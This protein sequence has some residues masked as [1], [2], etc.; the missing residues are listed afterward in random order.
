MVLKNTATIARQMKAAA[1]TAAAIEYLP[2]ASLKPYPGNAR[3]HDEEQI[4]VMVASFG[5]FGFLNPVLSDANNVIIAGH[6]RVEAAKRLG[7]KTVPVIRIGNLTPDQVRAYRIAD[8]RIAELAGWDMKILAIEFQHLT[9]VTVNFPVEAT[10]WTFPQIDM[11]IDALDGCDDTAADEA[12]QIP[13]LEEKAIARPGDL[14][15]CG[16]HLLLC[17]SALDG[18]NY[19]RLLGGQK[20]DLVCQDPPWNQ[21]MSSIGGKGKVTRREFVMASGEMSDAEFRAFLQTDLA[22]NAGHVRPGAVFQVFIDWRGVEKVITAGAA[23]DLR[24]INVCVWNK[25]HGSFGSPWR[26]A[27]EFIVA[28]A[29]PGAPIKDRV[30]L[31]R[32]GRVRSNVWSVPGMNSFGKGRAEALDMHPTSKPVQLLTEAI[33]DVTDRGDIVLD[34][35]MGSGSALIASARTGRIARGMELDPLYVDTILRRW[36]RWSGEPAILDGDGRSFTEVEAERAG[37]GLP[38]VRRRVRTS[39]TNISAGGDMSDVA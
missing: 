18:G 1:F 14:F 24:L 30:K 21:K 26:S 20:A 29:M 5:E 12:E 9:D 35:F 10:G 37:P 33:R 32:D 8:N 22:N 16:V 23:V 27:H 28:F 7:M 15:R 4:I 25:G 17:G 36:E 39:A 19:D 31:G 11:M 38:A 2:V 34:T 6:G 3:T 13:P